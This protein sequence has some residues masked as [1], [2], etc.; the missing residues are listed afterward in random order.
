MSAPDLAHAFG[1]VPTALVIRKHLKEHSEGAWS[2]QIAVEDARPMRERV[3]AIQR[4]QVDEIENKLALAE[5][6]AHD[7]NEAHRDHKKDEGRCPDCEYG[8][9]VARDPSD[10]FNILSKD[11]QSAISSILKAQGLTDRRELKTDSNR[12]DMFRLLIGERGGL[13]PA[14]LISDGAIEGEVKDVTDD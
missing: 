10:Y 7:F 1:G 12:V 6:R 14:H 5:Q 4:A 9:F 11:M 3:A 2:R 8:G 13:A